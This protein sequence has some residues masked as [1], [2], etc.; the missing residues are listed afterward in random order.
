MLPVLDLLRR[1]LP[2]SRLVHIITKVGVHVQRP[3]S[4]QE[5]GVLGVS[6]GAALHNACPTA[7]TP[8]G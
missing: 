3:S 4:E 1:S 7:Q 5:G 6:H 2:P 8:K